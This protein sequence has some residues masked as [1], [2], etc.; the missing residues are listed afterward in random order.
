VVARTLDLALLF[1]HRAQLWRASCLPVGCLV[2]FAAFVAEV[3]RT[4][5]GRRLGYSAD[6][7]RTRTEEIACVLKAFVIFVSGAGGPLDLARFGA[8]QFQ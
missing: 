3:E 7:R 5:R 6:P 4:G 2:R 8:E 1:R